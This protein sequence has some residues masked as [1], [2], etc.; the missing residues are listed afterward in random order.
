MVARDR[1]VFLN[2]DELG[3]EHR[4]EGRTVTIV[5]DNDALKERQGGAE[6]SVAESSLLFYA[7]EEDLPPRKAPGASMNVDGREYIVDDWGVDAGI[8]TVALSQTR[9]V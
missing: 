8:A 3:E 4:I 2:I 9:Q 5:I 7:A 6:L 1:A